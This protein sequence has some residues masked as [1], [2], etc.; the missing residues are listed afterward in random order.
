MAVKPRSLKELLLFAE[1]NTVDGVGFIPGVN[2]QE[3]PKQFKQRGFGYGAG[4][5]K[6]GFDSQ[7]PFIITDLPKVGSESTGYVIEDPSTLDVVDDL[8]NNFVRGG[9]VTL[10][11]RAFNDVER[12]G[13]LL[14]SPSGLAWSA[15]QLALARTNPIGPIP[16]SDPEAAADPDKNKFV[17]AIQRGVEKVK[18]KFPRNQVTLPLNLVLSAGV[19]AGGVRFRK[20]GLL[21]AKFESGYN[22]DPT[23]GGDKYENITVNNAKIINENALESN[24][25]FNRL[26]NIYGKHILSADLEPNMESVKI[27]SKK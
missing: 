20:D 23:R 11:K 21:D 14:F 2:T 8:S 16:E 24:K 10:A 22:Y 27:D 12:L 15:A 26:L 7:P 3:G 19:S 18:N 4:G 17:Q 9:A 6:F 1:N 25:N 5:G 13:K